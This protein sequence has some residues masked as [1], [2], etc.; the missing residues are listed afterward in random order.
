MMRHQTFR[1]SAGQKLRSACCATVF[2]GML[3]L[4][5]C[6]ITVPDLNNPSLEDLLGDRPNPDAVATATTGLLVGSRDNHGSYVSLLGIVGRE[7]FNLDPADPR[8]ISSVLA[9]DLNPG[10][11]AFGGNLWSLR[12]RNIQNANIVLGAV[13]RVAGGFSDA[14]KQGVRGFAKTLQAL[15]YLWVINTRHEN[16][17]VIV[18]Q[19]F[20]LGDPLPAFST[21]AQVL[22]HVNTLLDGAASDLQSAGGSFA[23]ALSP[24][25]AEFDT[26]ASF[27]AF[28][29]AIKARVLVYQG[30]YQGALQALQGSFLDPGAAFDLG[31]YHSFGTGSGDA[32]NPLFDPNATKLLVQPEVVQGAARDAGGAIIDQRL[33]AK[34][35]TVPSRSYQGVSSNFGFTLYNSLGAPIPI[36]RNE[37]LILLRAEARWF[38]GDKAGALADLNRVRTQSGGLPVLGMP[39]SDEAFVTALL[40]ERLYSLLFEGGHRW[41]DHRRF[42]R[43]AQLPKV[44]AEFVVPSAFPIPEP[45]ILARQ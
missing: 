42:D 19:G 10:D 18:P 5:G 37:E 27:L 41:L 31:A 29:R 2:A 38:T 35:D 43:L 14:D 12:Y 39:A 24:G 9:G 1:K 13:D 44:K 6:D 23:F 22:A 7:S 28:N 40:Y 4:T 3:V 25:F 32:T 45:E 11:A 15:D 16:G 26:P 8:Y 30:N 17:A 36:I 20:R 21:R 34:V 33:L